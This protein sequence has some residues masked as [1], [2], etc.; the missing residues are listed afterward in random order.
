MITETNQ[1]QETPQAA[2]DALDQQEQQVVQDPEEGDPEE[3]PEEGQEDREGAYKENTEPEGEEPDEPKEQDP[4]E[5]ED[6]ED[7]D[8]KSEDEDE[9]AGG[10]EEKKEDRAS[11]LSEHTKYLVKKYLSEENYD[12]DEDA[13]KALEEKIDQDAD[14]LRRN[15]EANRELVQI[16]Q[17]N[18]D[19]VDLIHLVQKGAS[20]DQAIPYVTGEKDPLIDLADNEK[21]WAKAAQEK[22]K[23]R[24]EQKKAVE[25][26]KANT[27]KSVKSIDA[28]AKKNNMDEKSTQ[29]FLEEIDRIYNEISRGLITE[30]T[31]TRLLKGI[32]YDKDI[33]DQAEKA[34]VRGRNEGIDSVKNKKTEGDKIPHPRST[35]TKEDDP[36]ADTPEQA[37]GRNLESWAQDRKF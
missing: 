25:A 10:E 9:R 11:E 27:Q 16:F 30:D 15:D 22:A 26:I 18:E 14:R 29:G 36:Q 32:S 8:E 28:F 24:D 33:K 21:E 12:N 4:G 17:D 34:E 6:P 31:M 7:E 20:V 1:D 3:S 5:G 2:G 35:A 37:F 23:K 13:V 19:L